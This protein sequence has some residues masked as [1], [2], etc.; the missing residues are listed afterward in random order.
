[1]IGPGVFAGA[2][3][4][5]RSI[6][7]LGWVLNLT[8]TAI[9]V[10]TCVLLLVALFRR[11]RGEP[12][13]SDERERPARRWVLIATVATIAILLG[14][15]IYSL[16]VLDE[17]SR[18]LERPGLTVRVIGFRYWWRVEYLNPDGSVDFV[19]ANEIHVPTG[20]SVH[21]LLQSGDVI[22]SFWMPTLAGKTQLIP[23][24][25]TR[26]WIEADTAG[27]YLGQCS[28]FCGT[29]HANM[30]IVMFADPPPRFTAWE[31]EQRTPA[32]VASA[33][34]H[35]LLSDHGCAAC[36]TIRGTEARGV[37]GPDLTHVGSRTTLASGLLPN[38]S[39]DLSRWLTAPDS[40][41]PGTLMP[42][43]ELTPQELRAMV[44]YL[45][46]LR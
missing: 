2:G 18:E 45:S 33:Q 37:V 6:A 10:L 29:S 14:V 4:S 46:S 23:G 39:D 34:D 31:A 36:H 44:K 1:M 12:G 42:N 40:V 25:T 41:K 5:G 35:T 27:R 20:T 30:R 38:T 8:G 15:F 13:L 22:H 43:V 7:V 16:R 19:T 26:M 3:S 24:Q 11:R 17:Y 28:A 32:A 9:L 21:L